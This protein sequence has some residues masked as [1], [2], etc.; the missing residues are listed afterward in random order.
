MA[1]T[2]GRKEHTFFFKAREIA[3]SAGNEAEYHRQRIAYWQG[4]QDAAV[5]IVKKTMGV[6]LEKQSM[7]GGYQTVVSVD[8][9]DPKAYYRMQTAERKVQSH[10]EAAERYET[11]QRLYF[12]QVTD[13]GGGREYELTTEDVHYFNLGKK[14]HE[15]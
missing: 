3:A 10:R 4:E 14:P 12:T 13:E 6:K 7:T 11:D 1:E 8:P 5:E 15:D 2:K 9:G